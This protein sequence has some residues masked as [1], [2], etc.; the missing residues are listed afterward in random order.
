MKFFI[1]VVVRNLLFFL[2]AHDDDHVF[3][4]QQYFSQFFLHV[5]VDNIAIIIILIINIVSSFLVVSVSR[6]EV[7][8]PCRSQ[9]VHGQTKMDGSRPRRGQIRRENL[10]VKQRRAIV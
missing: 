10:H 8:P 9:P 4:L 5:V 6:H 2:I 1:F 3:C 7:D